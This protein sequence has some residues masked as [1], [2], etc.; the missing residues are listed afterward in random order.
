MKSNIFTVLFMIVVG[1]SVMSNGVNAQSWGPRTLE[2]LKRET[3][4]RAQNNLGPITGIKA[5]DAERA[6][7]DLDRLDQDLWA[8]LWIRNGENYI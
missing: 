4:H 7:A 1:F 3:L 6:M 2:E 8:A 5:E